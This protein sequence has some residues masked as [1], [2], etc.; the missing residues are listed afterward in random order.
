MLKR[1]NTQLND[2]TNQNSLKSP[3]L[4]SQ[5]IRNRYYKTLGTKVI[6]SQLSPLYLHNNTSQHNNIHMNNVIQIIIP[7]ECRKLGERGNQVIQNI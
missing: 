6:K 1:L 3:K 4:F 7:E 5:Q 2:P